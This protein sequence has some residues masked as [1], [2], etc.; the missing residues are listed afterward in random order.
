VTNADTG[1]DL[2]LL[3]TT[4][5]A[6]GCGCGGCGCGSSA[7][8]ST[9]TSTETDTSTDPPTASTT[10]TAIPNKEST[11]ANQSYA[12]TGMTCGHCA[13]AV[14]TELTALDGVTDVQ[15]DLV[16]GGTSTVTVASLQPLEDTQVAA[17]LEEAGDYQL[18]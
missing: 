16:E 14:T 2:G 1:G 4:A 12:V 3:D 10:A 5:S 7:E 9:A 6:G 13:S 8:T 11:M 17:A 18:A 15:V